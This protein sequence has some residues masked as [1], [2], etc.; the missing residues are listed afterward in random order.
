MV[1][2]A[3]D[4]GGAASCGGWGTIAR[5]AVRC[6][7][8]MRVREGKRDSTRSIVF[9]LLK[10]CN[11]YMFQKGW[12]PGGKV[13]KASRWRTVITGLS[14]HADSVTISEVF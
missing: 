1:W 2:L 13:S 14:N 8:S 9:I 11:K 6:L 4:E 12:L 5:E 10:M 3:F 7:V